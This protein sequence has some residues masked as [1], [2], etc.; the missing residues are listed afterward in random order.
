MSKEPYP[1]NACEGCRLGMERIGPPNGP[2]IHAPHGWIC[3]KFVDPAI[4]QL[5]AE[6]MRK[7]VEKG[8]P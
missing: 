1:E 7:R 8:K 4:V 5:H 3:D 2:K 6:A